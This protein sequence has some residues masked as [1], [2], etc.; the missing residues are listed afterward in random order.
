MIR[1]SQG[2]VAIDLETTG[3]SPEQ[4][5]IIEIGAVK[6]RGDEVLD[7]YQT[8]VNPFRPLA[9]FIKRLTGIREEELEQAPPFSAVAGGLKEFLGGHPII[10]HNVAFDVA[11]LAR[12]GMALSNVPY[13]TWDLAAIL[14]PRAREYSLGLLAASLG[15][16]HPQPHRALADA[17]VTRQVFLA[18][19]ER[20]ARLDSGVLAALAQASRRS[21]TWLRHLLET[22][23][24]AAPAL[25]GTPT[26]VLGIDLGGLAQRLAVGRETSAVKPA[27]TLDGERIARLLGPDGP[28]A[29]AFPSYEH[30]PQQVEM[31]QAVANALREGG[32][33]VVEG[34]TGIG[35]SLAYLLPAVLFSLRTGKRVVVST[36]TIALQEQ[37]LTKDIPFLLK[38]LEGASLLSPGEFRATSLKGRAN[39][40]C[41]RRWAQLARSD[42]LNMAELRLLGKTLVWLQDT[43]TG[44][45]GEVNLAGRDYLMWERVSAGDKSYC[46]GT[47]E[48]V[49]FLRAARERAEAASL[50]V[51]NHALL[52]TDLARGGNLIP[53]YD[54][55]IVDEAHHLEEEATRQL[56]FQVSQR[57]LTDELDTLTRHLDHVRALLRSSKVD[58]VRQRGEGLLAEAEM[59]LPHLRDSWAAL[60]GVLLQ[61][62][63]KNR[64]R[65][66]DWLQL[67]LTASAR[68]QPAWDQVEL[69]WENLDSALAEAIK[70]GE[71]LH[72]LLESGDLQF[73]AD[74]TTVGMDLAAWSGEMQELKEHLRLLLVAPQSDR[75]HWVTQEDA[76]GALVLHDAP[77]SVGPELKKRLFDEKETVIL[78]SATLATQGTF[79]HVRGRLGLSDA[80]ELLVGSPFDYQ[81]AALVLLPTDVPE[82]DAPG[83]LDALR[84]ALVPLGEAMQGRTL[85]LFTSHS[86]VD[87]AQRALREPLEALGVGVMAQG[88]DGTPRQLVEAFTRN[89]KAV[90]LGTS[91]FWEGVDLS[92]GLVKALVIC[93]L[94]FNVP[95]DPVFAARSEQYEEPFAQYALPLAVLRFR[96]GFGRL[97]RGK[98]D[99]GIVLVMDRRVQ[100]RR[101]GAAFL[102]SLP[103]CSVRQVPIAELA[104]VAKEWLAP[105]SDR[106]LG[107]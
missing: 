83:Y 99:R 12:Q 74:G 53:K 2:C 92:G 22:L 63:Q 101:Y 52:L 43:R 106:G 58:A 54:H 34:G 8:L 86:A 42:S 40:L 23:E 82:P 71:A 30:R 37:L 102:K 97:I 76:D 35:K 77:Y 19:R 60:W 91:S 33:L 107:G 65:G 78:T 49:C 80:D 25:V 95:M 10:G 36:N 79:E 105:G 51:V 61:F 64:E 100:S 87:N 62:V 89:P 9:P 29:R 96:Q 27:V 44:D 50:L 88:I 31:A 94:P 81:K 26:G 6:F 103:Q 5:Q 45:R 13:D 59:R 1:P 39:Y 41:L 11:F 57:S 98:E 68:V 72:G 69:A 75:I 93:R 4:D 67:R 20:L 24:E 84:R 28:L 18:L 73:A 48:G 56:G 17:Q 14:L 70:S 15:I 90:L 104:R 46:P 32:H 16:T 38:A 7:T 3:L 47:T 21:P 55:L 66:T 85:A